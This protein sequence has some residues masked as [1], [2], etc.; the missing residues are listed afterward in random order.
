MA[1]LMLISATL[2]SCGE[3]VFFKEYVQLLSLFLIVAVVVSYI[4]L[5][6][7]LE[8]TCFCFFCCDCL[9]AVG[10][11]CK[12]SAEHFRILC[13]RSLFFPRLQ[14][15]SADHC[16]PGS[17]PGVA[18]SDGCFIF[19]YPSPPFEVARPI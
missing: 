15:A 13:P 5:V 6:L 19:D 11:R 8:R 3:G 9:M 14:I 12:H 16:H 1:V 17:N 2:S 7:R 18:I 4:V 10:T